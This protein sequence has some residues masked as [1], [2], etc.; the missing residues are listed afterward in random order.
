M[1]KNKW[2]LCGCLSFVLLMGQNLLFG[3][4][5]SQFTQF[6]YS[7]LLFNPAYAGSR[8]MM[9]FTGVYRNQWIGLEG[10]PQ[11]QR[12]SMNTP[13]GG[14]RIGLG[15]EIYHHS[16]GISKEWTITGSYAYRVTLGKGDLSVGLNSS[17]RY[18][19]IDYSDKRLSAT[20][21]MVPDNSSPQGEQSKTVPNFG[22]GL[23]YQTPEFYLG[24]S[25]P[26]LLRTNLD[27][28]DES[29]GLNEEVKHYYFMMGYQIQLNRLI[30]LHPQLMIKYV[31]NTPIDV[32]ANLSF[33]FADRFDLGLTYRLEESIDFLFAVK[34]N[35]RWVIG[36]SYDFGLHELRDYHSGS[37]EGV[38]RYCVGKKVFE[39]INPRFF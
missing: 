20:Q 16:I 17:I 7:K 37:L 1:R 29:D 14:E 23:Y 35:E 38:V 28:E 15:L 32:D 25:S 33:V 6:M 21:G 19:G 11:T 36:F 30:A 5:Q 13:V 12:I 31:E 39:V 26:R 24:I 27:F 34:A 8:G 4:Q 3:Q 2:I 18:M 9:C 10:A 22:V